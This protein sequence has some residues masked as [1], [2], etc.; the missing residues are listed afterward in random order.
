MGGGVTAPTGVLVVGDVINDV[1]VRPLAPTAVDTDTPA[2]VTATPGG[3]GANQAAWLAA[4][5]VPTRLCARVGGSD[6]SRHRQALA[7]LGVDARLAEDRAC[8]TGT[9]VVLVGG[10]GTRT[11][12][13]D[14][15]A[16]ERLGPE[17]IGAAALD[18]VSH[19]HVSGYALISPGP[20]AAV[21]DLWAQAG[22]AGLTRSI[23]PGSAS[24]LASME[25]GA[26]LEWTAG[27]DLAFPNLAEGALL[28][29]RD[30]PHDVARWLTDRY[31]LVAL[32]LGGHG[33]VVVARDGR[34][35]VA[36]PP[37]AD[38]P[39]VAGA[40]TRQVEDPTGAGDAFCAGFLAAWL[41]GGDL[42]RCAA[43]A[44]RLAGVALMTIGGRPP[45]P[46]AD[47][48]DRWP[49]LREAA[50]RV[51]GNA[52]APWSGLHV[53]AAGLTDDGRILAACNV[54]NA[55]FGLTLCAECGLVST[56]R[57]SGGRSFV[58]VSVVA[59]DGEPLAPCG[60]CRQVLLDNGGPDMSID[61]GAGHP[62]TRL[63]DLLPG[64]FDTDELRRR[65]P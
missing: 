35:V 27:A 38:A 5:G 52:F 16:N 34:L 47:G 61:A 45:S 13:S 46:R 9:I 42:G 33:A 26:F 31:P 15:G 57:A 10:D 58:A 53:G 6:A 20:R 8:Q 54:E 37:A 29:G 28:A 51:A 50:R 62:P 49:P 40:G 1:I 7:E 44:T 22:A 12:Y 48:A 25:P 19:L 64:A 63:G 32:K 3:S 23:D 59:A 41:S 30:D 14:R 36:D 24:F 18:G 4:A 60:R 43:E 65:S 21:R 55:S 2:D 39:H 11:M 17:D 56:L